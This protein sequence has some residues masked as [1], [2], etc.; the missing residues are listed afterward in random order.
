MITRFKIA[1]YSIS[2]KDDFQKI[3]IIISIT[4]FFKGININNLKYILKNYPILGNFKLVIFNTFIKIF[5]S[6]IET[7][8]FEMFDLW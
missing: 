8:F 3:V 4:F 7:F 5:P 6:Q 1:A 2:N